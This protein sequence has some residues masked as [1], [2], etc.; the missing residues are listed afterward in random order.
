MAH[1][2]TRTLTAALALAVFSQTLAV[3]EN[4][5]QSTRTEPPAVKPT[6]ASNKAASTWEEARFRVPAGKKFIVVT[7]AEPT[8]RNSCRVQ[9]VTLDRL[10]C[11]RPFRKTR[12]YNSQQIAALIT[13]GDKGL[14]R[15]LFFGFNGGLGAAIWGTLILAPV[16]VPCAVGTGVAAY[17]FF[18]AAGVVLFSGFEPDSLLY[19]A[20]GQT[21]QVKLRH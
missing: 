19:L 1:P 14:W 21:L 17:F 16:C 3:A 20:P 2:I 12:A 11:K 15:V 8:H 18:G 5:D 6:P 4:P 7:L 10:T 13:P 9:S